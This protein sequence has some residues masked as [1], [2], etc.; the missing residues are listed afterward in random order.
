VTIKRY[1]EDFSVEEMLS[2]EAAARISAEPGHCALYRLTKRGLG[3]DEALDMIAAKLRIPSAG[4]GYAGLKDK[5]AATT[6]YITIDAPR[7]DPER[8]PLTLDAPRLKLERIGWLERRLSTDDMSG[9]RFRITLRSLTRRRC[10]Q[11]SDA[12]ARYAVPG[13]HGKV[14]RFVNY[15]GEQRF[16]SARHGQG[17]AARHLMKG[18]FEEALRLLIAVPDRKDPRERKAAKRAIAARWG[19]WKGLAAALP[20]CPERR[21]VLQLEE[22][23][24]D[25]REGFSVLPY[26]IRQMTIEAYQSW[27]WNEVARRFVTQWCASPFTKAASKFGELIFPKAADIPAGSDSLI[28]PLF[29]PRIDFDEPWRAAAEA[30]LAAEGISLQDLRIPGMRKPY[31]GGVARRLIVDATEFSL[32]P[33]QRD[34]TS[35]RDTKFKRVVRFFLPRG[36]YGTVLLRALLPQSSLR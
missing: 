5:H 19:D 25:F 1:P 27:I 35:G 26:F 17:F 36:S 6:Q 3:T 16:G 13:S 18:D 24:G 28:I 9:N 34:E 2:R 23:G 10:A 14:L 31:F 7:G 4:I 32:G 20:A 11:L 33:L 12:R 30:V 15:Y 21:V 22:S 29:S 8:A